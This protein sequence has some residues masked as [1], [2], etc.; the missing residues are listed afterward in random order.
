M[1][2][3]TQWTW[4]WVGAIGFGASGSSTASTRLFVPAG[5]SRHSSGGAVS[6]PS[7]VWTVGISPWSSKAGER[8]VKGILASLLPLADCNLRSRDD[9]GMHHFDHRA[10]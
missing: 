7:H 8:N 9:R 3:S 2:Y 6:A 1:S 5:T 4:V 10:V